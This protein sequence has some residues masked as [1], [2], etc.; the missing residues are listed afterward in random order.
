MLV[1]ESFGECARVFSGFS[2][3]AAFLAGCRRVFEDASRETDV[4]NVLVDLQRSTTSGFE[5]VVFDALDFFLGNLGFMLELEDLTADLEAS[6]EGAVKA[7]LADCLRD[8]DCNL[9]GALALGDSLESLLNRVLSAG[10]A[11][12][13]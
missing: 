13:E 9:L 4:L 7:A 12:P 1:L 11:V 10:L 3:D 8:E 2:A 6:F 5:G